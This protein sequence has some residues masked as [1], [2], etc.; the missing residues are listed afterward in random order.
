MAAV[1]GLEMRIEAR[2]FQAKG[3][4]SGGGGLLMVLHT[5]RASTLSKGGFEQCRFGW[6]LL[7][8]PVVI[9]RDRWEARVHTLG[10]IRNPLI[11]TRGGAPL[12]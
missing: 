12:R 10:V 2:R 1:K 6:S 5:T 3:L 4:L 7:V 9:V 11:F 8:A